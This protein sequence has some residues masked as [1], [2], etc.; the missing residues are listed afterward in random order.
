M[1]GLDRGYILCYMTG[2][3]SILLYIAKHIFEGIELNMRD[4]SWKVSEKRYIKV[5]GNSFFFTDEA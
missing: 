3:V 2:H 4:K 1:D 5:L